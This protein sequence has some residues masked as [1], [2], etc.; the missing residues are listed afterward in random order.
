MKYLLLAVLASTLIFTVGCEDNTKPHAQSSDSDSDTD[1]DGDTDT[2]TDTDGD[3]DSDSDT[4]TGTGD[5]ICDEFQFEI[6]AVPVRMVWLLDISGSMGGQKILDAKAA[7]NNILGIWGGSQIEF[8]FDYYP[9]NA[10]SG[11]NTSCPIS[12][13]T[14]TEA[15]ITTMVNGLSASGGTPTFEAMT[16][17]MSV[18]Y[19]AGFPEAGVESYLVLVTDGNPNNGTPADYTNLTSSLLANQIKTVAIGVQ[20]SGTTLGAIAAAGGMPAPYNVPIVAT[21]LTTLQ[22]AFNDIAGAIINCIYDITITNDVD[23][24]SVNFFFIDS[25]GV[26]TVVPYDEDC[27]S[28]FAWHWVDSLTHEQIEFCPDACDL[29]QGGDVEEIKGEFGCPQIIVD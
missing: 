2:D 7:V 26:E 13:T 1:T 24:D 25:L 8:G 4:D 28:G 6:E 17:Y 21:D 12:P 27:S 19:A 18:G 15:A 16:N 20:Y 3:T 14:G 10:S 29:L 23:Y 9:N 5:A 22:A 11:V